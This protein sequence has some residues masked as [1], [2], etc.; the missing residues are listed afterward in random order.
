MS[1]M[2]LPML[3]KDIAFQAG[4]RRLLDGVSLRLEAGPKTVILGPNGAG[5]SLLMR[6]AHGL[7]APSAGEVVWHAPD[8]GRRQAMV[9][10]RPVLLR[11]SVAANVDHALALAGVPPRRRAAERE[12]ALARTGLAALA[13]QPARALSGGEQ[14]RLA[15]ARAWALGPQVVFLD[16]P[17]ASLD[18]S[19]TRA[20]EGI[21]EAMH[22]SGTK[23]VMVTQ[24]LG[25]ARRLADE[26]V[27]LHRGQVQEVTPAGR[28]F[29]GPRSPA[30]QAFVAGELPW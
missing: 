8:P 12:A 18:P 19:A 28:F 29:G 16:E 2:I 9:F 3:L 14:Q 30:A 4:G 20:V 1:G 13:R 7:V 22:A 5:K 23:I 25:Q 11:R 26:V 15:L 6:I 10:Q 17:T 21:V 24:D 27:F